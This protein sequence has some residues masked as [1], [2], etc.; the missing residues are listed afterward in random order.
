MENNLTG[1]YSSL[2]QL[3]IDAFSAADLNYHFI[4]CLQ[5]SLAVLF[6][7]R[8]W[9]PGYYSLFPEITQEIPYGQ[10]NYI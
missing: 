5:E 7:E 9:T 6:R 3:R 1:E 2:N 8:L 10:S 4:Q